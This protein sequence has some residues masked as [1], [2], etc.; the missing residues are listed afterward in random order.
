VHCSIDTLLASWATLLGA[1]AATVLVLAQVARARWV[2]I[3]GDRDHKRRALV[4]HAITMGCL[5]RE[6]AESQLT[7]TEN[8]RQLS[9]ALDEALIER[10]LKPQVERALALWLGTKSVP[11]EFIDA[12]RWPLLYK[13]LVRDRTY[14]AKEAPIGESRRR[15][16]GLVDSAN[17][18]ALRESAR[19]YQEEKRRAEYAKKV[20]GATAPL[21][22][23]ALVT[24]VCLVL[25]LLVDGDSTFQVYVTSGLVIAS[26]FS[27]ASLLVAARVVYRSK[28]SAPDGRREVGPAWLVAVFFAFLAVG[29]AAGWYLLGPSRDAA[30]KARLA[31]SKPAAPPVVCPPKTDSAPKTPPP[32]KHGKRPQKPATAKRVDTLYYCQ[33]DSSGVPRRPPR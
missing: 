8:D 17:V 1:F 22:L 12:S 30:C 25:A 20:V 2:E 28:R 11:P 9:P 10:H 16:L 15:L 31:E 33:T 32:A 6:G 21:E 13:E 14:M 5:A 27:F 19:R 18:Q 4:D 3:V 7:A 24:V 29:F 23:L 26:M